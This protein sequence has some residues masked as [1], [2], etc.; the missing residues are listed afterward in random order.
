MLSLSDDYD[1][2][3][4]CKSSKLAPTRP[5]KSMTC[6]YTMSQQNT[7]VLLMGRSKHLSSTSGY[8]KPLENKIP[9]HIKYSN[10]YE[11]SKKKQHANDIYHSQFSNIKNSTHYDKDINDLKILNKE[12][13][14]SI[15][16][17]LIKTHETNFRGVGQPL[18][19]ALTGSK[20]GPGIYDII[21]SLGKDEVKK[22]LKVFR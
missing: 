10:Q 16:N 9:F 3:V 5:C 4:V 8:K 13:L 7:L 15:V 19:V 2:V 6:N 20:F 17:D 21:I 18:R 22:R 1:F 11:P 14:E 12:T